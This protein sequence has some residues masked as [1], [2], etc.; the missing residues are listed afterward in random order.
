MGN[1]QNIKS[2]LMDV[3]QSVN[4]IPNANESFKHEL[5]ELVDQLNEELQKVPPEKS[6]EA[7]AVAETTKSLVE[8]VGKEKPNK[9]MV[10][11]NAEGLKQAAKN[12]ATVTSI[13]LTIAT[14]IETAIMKIVG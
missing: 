3:S 10:Q 6:E 8:T 13:V 4:T 9:T 12:L 7:E 2:T 11:V 1:H 5:R 14:Q